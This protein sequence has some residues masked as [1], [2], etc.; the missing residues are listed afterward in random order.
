[1]SRMEGKVVLVTGGA[2]GIGAAA[3]H[4]LHESGARVCVSDIRAPDERATSMFVEHDVASADS[5][6]AVVSTVQREFGR[7]DGLVNSAGI[8]RGGLIVDTSLETWEEVIGVNQTGILLGMQFCIDL[9]AGEDGG[10]IVNLS[11]YAGMQGHGTSIAYQAAKWAVRGMTRFAAREFAPRGVRVNAL[12]PGF[13]DTP[14]VRAAP[15]EQVEFMRSRVPLRR[16]GTAT[17]AAEAIQYLLSDESSYVT[18]VELPVD[19]GLLA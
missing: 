13:I 8:F 1:M 2:S 18:G 9:L 7:L 11:S 17:E 10:S 16:L 6:S 3:A 19:G 12:A 15:A 14:M 4:R 5:W